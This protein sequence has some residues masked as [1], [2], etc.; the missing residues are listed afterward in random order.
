METEHTK[1]AKPIGELNGRWALLFKVTQVIIPIFI[2]AISGI[3]IP[4]CVWVTKQL[5]EHTVAIITAQKWQEAH[6]TT[7]ANRAEN[8]RMLVKAEIAAEITSK[9]SDKIEAMNLNIIR[10][11]EEVKQ[12]R[13]QPRQAVFSTD[14]PTFSSAPLT[15]NTPF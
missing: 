5:N 2:L 4:W 3:G 15:R 14:P 11:Q 7:E 9:L 8:L 12:M 10:L 1:R 13:G 6:P